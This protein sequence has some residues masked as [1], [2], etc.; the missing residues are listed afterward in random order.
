MVVSNTS[1]TPHPKLEPPIFESLLPETTIGMYQEDIEINCQVTGNPTPVVHW[2]KDGYDFYNDT[3]RQTF[4]SRVRIQKLTGTDRGV[5]VCVAENKA[6][7]IR[8]QTNLV[9]R[10]PPSP[11]NVTIVGGYSYAI[12]RY[13]VEDDGGS[14]A[15]SLQMEL[16]EVLPRLTQWV[17]VSANISGNQGQYILQGLDYNASY[18]LNI[19][20]MNDIGSGPAVMRGFKTLSPDKA[21][22]PNNGNNSTT[23]ARTGGGGSSTLLFVAV[24][25][26]VLI[27]SLVLVFLLIGRLRRL[28]NGDSDDGQSLVN[29]LHE[30]IPSHSNPGY[31]M[32]G[33]ALSGANGLELHDIKLHEGTSK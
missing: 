6:G 16:R 5:Y 27:V 14:Q 3:H 22:T 24:I 26:A 1:V 7:E 32:D 10:T 33:S 9:I 13:I 12:V 30:N 4:G 15:T 20:A 18:E 11:L 17:A 23:V 8:Q 28:L 2:F 25:A 31:N 21:Y 19:W 29:N